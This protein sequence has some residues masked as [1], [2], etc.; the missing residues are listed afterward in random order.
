MAYR[1]SWLVTRLP[2]ILQPHIRHVGVTSGAAMMH[3]RNNEVLALGSVALATA[4]VSSS[5]CCSGRPG[6]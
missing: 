1:I 6:P 3:A 4:M 2:F 5:G